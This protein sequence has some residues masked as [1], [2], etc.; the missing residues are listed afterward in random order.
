MKL[1]QIKPFYFRAFCDSAPV[2]FN[3]N[4][5]IFYGGNGAGKSSLSEA[6]EWL[7]YGYTK[8]RRKGDEYS[9]NEYKGS[10]V[11]SA[12][13]TGTASYV[14][15]E[16]RLADGSTH[17]MRRTIKLNRDGLPLDQEST[18]SIDGNPLADFT[19]LNL[20]FTEAHCPVIVQHGIQDFIHTRPIDRYRVISEALGLSELVEFKDVLERA[21]IQRRNNPTSEVAQAK[22]ITGQLITKLRLVDLATLAARWQSESYSIDADYSLIFDKARELSGSQAVTVESVLS[23]VR[24]RQSEEINKVFDIAPFRP[25]PNL[26]TTLQQIQALVAQTGD[27]DSKFKLAA[28]TYAGATA[29]SYQAA[30]LEFWRQG[31]NLV[32]KANPEQCPFC[33]ERT[34]T[35]D[36]IQGLKTRLEADQNLSMSR[37]S[38]MRETDQYVALLSQFE[39]KLSPLEFNSISNE[40][41]SALEKL[42]ESDKARL[43]AFA[44][45]NRQSVQLVFSLRETITQAKSSLSNLK[46]SITQ[47]DKIAKAVATVAEI[48]TR[49]EKAWMEAA[50]SLKQYNET[51]SAFRPIFERELSDEATVKKFSS[52]IEIFSD[53]ASVRLIAEAKAFDNEILEAQRLVEEH[54]LTQQKVALTGR[55]TEILNWYSLLSPNTDVKFSGLEPGRNEFNLKA[56]AFG[57]TMSAAASLSQSQLNC[58]GLSI[59]IPS[60]SAPDSPFK[61]ILFDDP[62][63]AMDDDHHESFLV[64]VVPELKI[65]HSFQVIVLTHLKDTA[66]R[67]RDRNFTGNFMYYRFDKL[68]A[69]GPII[70]EHLVLGDDMKKIRNF[71]QGN[72]DNR[73]M[74]VDRIRVLCEN[75]MREYLLNK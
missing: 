9:K 23:D 7:F 67:L 26:V 25:N 52:L 8:R 60:V 11:H 12:C 4:L 6:V 64:N 44:I 50:A 22:A 17:L 5:T 43:R 16:V 19:L 14:E 31:L 63:Q 33:E 53:Y 48:P 20:S 46:T 28:A 55:E 71:A 34:I 29:S 66:D 62:V 65:K 1:L 72:D 41:E 24:T 27:A 68:Q 74:A 30:Q 70:V 15:A 32:D 35:P 69:T 36:G 58:L 42:F 3:D 39:P 13:P 56:E 21:K 37:T 59:Y 2:V 54:I 61:F 73:E 10:Y 38:F 45:E 49:I 18:L 75:I 40:A 51:Y 57:R 47:P